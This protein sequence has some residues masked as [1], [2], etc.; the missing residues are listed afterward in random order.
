MLSVFFRFEDMKET[1]ELLNLYAGMQRINTFLY[2]DFVFSPR[3]RI[4]RHIT[5]W[6]LHVLAWAFFWDVNDIFGW[7]YD[8]QVINLCIWV[9][10]F[11]LFSYPMIYWGIPELLLKE[12]VIEFLILIF[13]W[14]AVGLLINYAYRHYLYVPALKALRFPYIPPK[15]LYP[16]S[17]LC[18]TTSA[19][20][21]V[22]I[23][24]YKL[25]TI[26]QRDVLKATE[27]KAL[28]EME[29]L[30][31]Q[32]H[33]HF[34]FNT[35]NNIYS[36]SINKSPQTPSLILKLTSL[37]NYMMYDCRAE[38]VELENE[39]KVMKNYI[40]LEKERYG[41]TLELHWNVKGNISGN[42]IAP[43]LMLPF[44]ENAFKHGI[45]EQF[46]KPLLKVDISANDGIL[47]FRVVNS[48]NS[49]VKQSE[50]GIGIDNVKKRLAFIYPEIHELTISDEPNLY[51]VSM[52]INLLAQRNWFNTF[53]TEVER[54]AEEFR[55]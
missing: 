6:I 55:A 39:I 49:F 52:K 40:D 20:S 36:F 26:K 45:S 1:P 4:W 54:I 18:M 29:L 14:A 12:K 41:N 53:I 50:T 22:I 33:P 19:A 43:L 21:C 13:V 15:E 9:P 34:L 47:Q 10:A 25:W 48:K 2:N 35:L 44:L 11:I 30:K 16:P 42:K 46:D 3:Y 5:Y 28:A 8:L 31:N 23:R 7:T 51:I 38:E 27:E 17:Y 37:L 24:F 32:I